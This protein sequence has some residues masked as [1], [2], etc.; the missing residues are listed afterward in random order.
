VL[1]TPLFDSDWFSLDFAVD[2]LP[3]FLRFKRFYL[4]EVGQS[5]FQSW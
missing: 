4:P 3:R 1:P 2:L 5:F